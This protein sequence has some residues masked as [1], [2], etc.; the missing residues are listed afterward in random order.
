M[1]DE[2]IEALTTEVDRLAKSLAILSAIVHDFQKS[3]PQASPP[4]TRWM[5]RAAQIETH[6]TKDNQIEMV[7]D[8]LQ[9]QHEKQLLIDTV[10]LN[11]ESFKEKNSCGGYCKYHQVNGHSIKECGAFKNAIQDLIDQGKIDPTEFDHRA[12]AT[13]MLVTS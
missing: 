11:Q 10:D 9:Q 12:A 8:A 6:P 1:V 4:L 5:K 13:S 2:K 3:P 7:V